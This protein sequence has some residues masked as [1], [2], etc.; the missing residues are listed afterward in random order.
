MK[1]EVNDFHEN[2]QITLNVAASISAISGL[3]LAINNDLKVCNVHSKAGFSEEFYKG[4]KDMGLSKLP[5]VSCFKNKAKYF[6]ICCDS[7][8]SELC[9][10]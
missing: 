10:S 7:F 1:T 5:E 3:E 4:S 6:K 8:C 2:W 9:L